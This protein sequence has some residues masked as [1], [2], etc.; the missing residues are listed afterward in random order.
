MLNNLSQKQ[1]IENRVS[2]LDRIYFNTIDLFDCSAI[3]NKI[4]ERPPG[5]LPISKK[6]KQVWRPQNG[7]TCKVG[8]SHTRGAI[9]YTIFCQ[10]RFKKF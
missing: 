3:M 6:K 1:Y 5:R 10:S 2:D 8:R 7:L 9:Q 4:W